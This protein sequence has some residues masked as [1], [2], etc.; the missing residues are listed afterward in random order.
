MQ[1]VNLAAIDG[2]QVNISEDRKTAQIMFGG[3]YP[4]DTISFRARWHGG[5]YKA[6]AFDGSKYYL[7]A[8]GVTEEYDQVIKLSEPI[9]TSYQVKIEYE[10]EFAIEPDF[11]VL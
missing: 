5:K 9:L 7:I 8:E 1:R 10:R 2:S 11:K 4:F 3:I 6:Y